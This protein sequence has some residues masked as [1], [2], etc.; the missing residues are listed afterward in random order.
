MTTPAP[1]PEVSIVLPT[2]NRPRLLEEAINSLLAQTYSNWKLFVVDDASEPP[3]EATQDSRITI[4]RNVN[5][6]GGAAAKNIGIEHSQGEIVAY[7]DDDD[8]YA[9]MYLETAVRFL[10]NHP[11]FD[12]VFMGV[13]WFGERGEAGEKAYQ[14]AMASLFD[15]APPEPI[16]DDEFF[17]PN[18]KL[19]EALLRTVPMAFQRPVVRRS[20]L[21]K[22]GNYQTD[23]LLW[24]SDWA[25]RAALRANCAL[26]NSGLYL[27]R[28]QGQGF[29]SQQNRYAEHFSSNVK[30]KE[31]LLKDLLTGRQRKL[32]KESVSELW[33]DAAWTACR[34]GDLRLAFRNMINSA[35]ISF[36]IKHFKLAARIAHQVVKQGRFM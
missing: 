21:R 12:L 1:S 5:S 17:F 2:H 22:I 28:A 26:I 34:D 8:L 32:V 3:A 4:L 6:T 35:K 7:L 14:H 9:P 18:D 31:R 11:D 16:A 13:S 10:N 30:M 29:S 36:R 27:Q 19:F 15:A 25:I 24:D 20:A 33:F 23:V